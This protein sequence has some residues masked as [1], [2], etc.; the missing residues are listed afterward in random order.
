MLTI[1]NGD[2]RMSEDVPVPQ[3]DKRAAFDRITFTPHS[4]RLTR[5]ADFLIACI[6]IAF[7]LPL[8]ILVALAIK[9]TGPGPVLERQDCIGGGGRRFKLLKFRT[10][11]PSEVEAVLPWARQ[12]TPLGEFLRYT[13]IDSLPQ[14]VNVLRDEMSILDAEASAPSFL[15]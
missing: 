7:C 12:L 15:E 1:V 14:L 13:R 11:T 2:S 10:T 8:I 5:I 4:V 3:V 9:A 6:L